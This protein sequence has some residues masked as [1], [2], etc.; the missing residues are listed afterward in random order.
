MVLGANELRTKITDES[1]GSGVV[2]GETPELAQT[3]PWFP[4]G[5]LGT[6]LKAGVQDKRWTTPNTATTKM[7]AVE[8]DPREK[9][10]GS[11]ARGGRAVVM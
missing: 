4:L 10:N 8:E 9:F 3:R 5:N 11:K 2:G 7:M 6:V 1:N